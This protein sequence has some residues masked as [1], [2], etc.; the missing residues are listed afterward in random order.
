[1]SAGFR[2]CIV[3]VWFGKSFP[4]LFPLW[5][6]TVAKNPDVDFVMFGDLK[7]QGELPRNFS[8]RFMTLDELEVLA[9]TRLNEPSLVIPTPYKVCDYKPMFGE[10]F[11]EYLREYDFWGHCDLDMFLGDLGDFL[12]PDKLSQYDKIY[13]NGHL[14]LYRNTPEVNGRWRLPDAKFDVKMVLASPMNFAFD[15]WDGIY[16]IYRRRHFPF[17]SNVEFAEPVAGFRRFRLVPQRSNSKYERRPEDHPE[18]LFY[19]EDGKFRRTYV[20]AAGALITEAFAYV[21][22]QKWRFAEIAPD[23]LNADAFYCTSSGFVPKRIPGPP[24]RDEIRRLNPPRPA[25]LEKFLFWWIR[26][27]RHWKRKITGKSVFAP[28]SLKLP[29]KAFT[30]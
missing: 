26:K 20:D 15:E 10:L 21:H 22:F 13:P 16:N 18:Q 27:K 23:V 19:W 28:K 4:T 11:Q 7:P 5:L 8:H 1:M 17:Y 2:I 12:T 29:G 25:W 3:N 24:S 9:R 6:K 30:E 14:S